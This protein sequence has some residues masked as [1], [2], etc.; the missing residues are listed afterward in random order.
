MRKV[1]T[2][3]PCAAAALLLTLTACATGP[4]PRSPTVVDKDY[5]GQVEAHAKQAGV[6]VYW[7]NPPRVE[8]KRENQ[9]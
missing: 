6:D 8:R 1:R 9:S 7:I 2:I 4:A 3:L 5:V